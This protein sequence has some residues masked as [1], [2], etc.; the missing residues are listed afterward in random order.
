MAW[1]W[2]APVVT[3]IVGVSGIAGTYLNGRRQTNVTVQL[4]REE[5]AQ[6]RLERAYLEVQRVVERSAQWAA[7]AMPIVGGSGQDLYP[8]PPADDAQVLEASAL[9]LYWSPEV[10]ELVQAWTVARNRLA[11]HV[12]AARSSEPFRGEAWLA[13]PE[14]KQGLQDA[15][16]ALVARMSRELLTVE[17]V[18][19]RRWQTRRL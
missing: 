14:L 16:D 13:V 8:P 5:R 6:D 17:P 4:A 18:R 3:G 19:R 15:I 10:R 1:E 11:G 12:L 7:S 9:R 2:V